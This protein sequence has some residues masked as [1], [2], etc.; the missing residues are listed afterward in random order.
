MQSVRYHLKVYSSTHIVKFASLYLH[1]EGS[2]VKVAHLPITSASPAFDSGLVKFCSTCHLFG[3]DKM[4]AKIT[5]NL[6][7]QGPLFI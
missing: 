2:G 5:W 7:I 3:I 6:N 1:I 4:I